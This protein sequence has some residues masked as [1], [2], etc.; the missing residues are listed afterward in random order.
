[1]EVAFFKKS[2]K[3]N[4]KI[5]RSAADFYS[6]DGTYFPVELEIDRIYSGV[7][8]NYNRNLTAQFY[9]QFYLGM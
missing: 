4:D 6:N 9:T 5:Y 7:L 1:M 3:F 2:L 8:A